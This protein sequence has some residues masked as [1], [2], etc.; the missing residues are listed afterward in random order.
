MEVESENTDMSLS[1]SLD[2]GKSVEWSSDG[3][4]GLLSN[5]RQIFRPSFHRFLKDMMRFN[6]E[7]SKIL[8]LPLN[9]PR[10]QVTM[11]QYLRDE[12][13]SN[14]F[15]TYYL[16]PMMAALWSASIGNVLDFPACQLIGFMCNHKMLQ[17]FDRPQV[18]T[19]TFKRSGRCL[20]LNFSSPCSK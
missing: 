8:T 5:K 18:S 1:V 15:G 10:R 20:T 2:G 7:A 19:L 4:S 12:G 17:V 6:K 14:E 11:S 3:I 16:L 13:Y 9:D